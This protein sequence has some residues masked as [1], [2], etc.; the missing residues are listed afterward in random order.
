[1]SGGDFTLVVTNTLTGCSESSSALVE[2][3]EAFPSF[4][5][6]QED[7]SCFGFADGSLTLNDSITGTPPYVFLLN[8]PDANNLPP[9]GQSWFDLGPGNYT[10]SL[11]DGIGCETSQSAIIVEPAEMSV[12]IGNDDFQL[13]IGDTVNLNVTNLLDMSMVQ[14]ITWTQD[15]EVL[16]EGTTA[17][18]TIDNC[19]PLPVEPPLIPT[20]YCLIVTTAEG[21][22]LV[23]CRTLQAQDVRD[24]Y[25]PTVITDFDG[26]VEANTT[27]Y[28]HTDEFVVSI[29]SFAIYDRWG[30]LI[31]SYEGGFPNDPAWGWNG[32]FNGEQAAQGVY[33]YIIE[34][35]YGNGDTEIFTGSITVT[36]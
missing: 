2:T 5:L 17:D 21:C 31:H 29:P 15:G 19:I 7:I 22:I 34:L 35:E 3:D 20:E 1:M 13:A 30:E 32:Y 25:F 16:C 10:I 18:G 6:A 36:R 28:V 9:V 8:G 4:S 33:V 12:E 24:V 23:D 11:V 14:S 27:F 26:D